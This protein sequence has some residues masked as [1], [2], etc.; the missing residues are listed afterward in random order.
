MRLQKEV[1]AQFEHDKKEIEVGKISNRESKKRDRNS[2]G[3]K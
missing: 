1:K 3:Y 2:Y